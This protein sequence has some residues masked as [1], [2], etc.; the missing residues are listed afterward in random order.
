MIESR[1]RDTHRKDSIGKSICRTAG[2]PDPVE[3]VLARHA[4]AWYG[5]PAEFFCPSGTVGRRAPQAA[6]LPGHL[7][8]DLQ[9]LQDIHE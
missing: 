4:N 7:R 1:G 2:S 5:M 9:D 3:S 8:Q 6:Q